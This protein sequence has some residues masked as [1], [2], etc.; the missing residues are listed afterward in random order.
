MIKFFKKHDTDFLVV[1]CNA[2]G[3]SA[4]HFIARQMA[5]ISKELAGV[6]LPH[7]AFSLHLDENSVTVDAEKEVQKF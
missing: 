6:L 4:Y 3:L 7:D 1:V 2:A 5:P